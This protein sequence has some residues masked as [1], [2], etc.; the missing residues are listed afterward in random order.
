MEKYNVISSP[1]QQHLAFLK[2][3]FF[4]V[5]SLVLVTISILVS[6]LGKILKNYYN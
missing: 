6:L 5:I 4:M 3:L 2:D 1:L